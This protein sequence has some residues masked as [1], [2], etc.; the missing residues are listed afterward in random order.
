MENQAIFKSRFTKIVLK[1][2][3]SMTDF[4]LCGTVLSM[5]SGLE[6]KSLGHNT[7]CTT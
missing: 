1:R 7:L 6:T 4:I 3:Y 5:L 2:A